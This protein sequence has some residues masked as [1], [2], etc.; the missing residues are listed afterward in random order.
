MKKEGKHKFTTTKLVELLN[1]EYGEKKSGE[2]FTTNDIQQYLR[3]GKLPMYIGGHPIKRFNNEKT[4][5]KLVEINF[6]KKAQRKK[7]K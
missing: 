1:E 6:D 5:T 7:R 2:P 4:G 3:R